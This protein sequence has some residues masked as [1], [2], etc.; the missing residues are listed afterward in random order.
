MNKYVLR[1]SLILLLTAFIWGTAFVAQSAGMEYVGTFTFNACRNVL[2]ALVLIPVIL[3]IRKTEMKKPDAELNSPAIN[4]FNAATVKG[5]IACGIILCIASNLQQ[6]AL[7]TAST[8]KAG[9]ITAL[10]ILM[11]PILGLFLKKRV[12]IK[13]WIGVV[14]SLVGLYLLCLTDT[15]G[16]KPEDYLLFGC[17][18]VFSLHITVVDHFSAEANG[19]AMSA[20][21][22]AVCAIL[23]GIV[24]F[25]FE[26]PVW[27]QI[28]DCAVPILYA[29]IL[30]S[31]VAYTLQIVGQK[32]MNP[33]IASMIMSLESVFSA[34]A[35]LV[36]LHQFL[37]GRETLGCILM[38]AA[39]ILAQLPDRKAAN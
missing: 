13:I 35:G 7:K 8:G 39:I 20:I 33:T 1:Q 38:F 30:S 4:V 24:M 5:G 25:I 14:I 32:G 18:F 3:F 9:F 15:T 36:I 10:Y 11:V 23:S 28:A 6:H 21:Q 17:A 31:G 29:G 22:F 16:L 34:L 27:T 26:N 37:S 19:V 2:G 12:G